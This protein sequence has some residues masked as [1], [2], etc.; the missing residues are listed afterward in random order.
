[1]KNSQILEQRYLNINGEKIAVT[2]EVY[3]EYMRPIWT[4]HKR[5]ERE[6]RC[7]GKSGNRCMND[8][9][10][11]IKDYTG[12][13][14]SLEQCVE[15]GFDVADSI[16]IGEVVAN[17]LLHEALHTA[18][19]QLEPKNRQIAELFAA[20]FSEREIAAKVGLSQK[21]INGRKQKIFAELRE[22]LKDLR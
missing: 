2:E 14:L 5:Q 4:A 11:C 22:Y 12:R 8:C 19:D 15:D 10:A 13:P 18:L 17:K 20:G 16:D 9:S 7:Q 1:M 3:R 6:K 21:G